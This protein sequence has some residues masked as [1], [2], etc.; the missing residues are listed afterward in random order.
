MDIGIIIAC[1]AMIGL[2]I[3]IVIALVRKAKASSCDKLDCCA[4]REVP[5]VRPIGPPPPMPSCPEKKV[6]NKRGWK[7]PSG[8]YFNDNDELFTDAGEMILDM[9]I[10]AQLCGEST[11]TAPNV[12]SL[13]PDPVSEP[14]PVAEVTSESS[15]SDLQTATTDYSASESTSCGGG[16]DSDGGDCGGGDD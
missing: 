2:A 1:G 5:G 8:H 15:F 16:S 11:T 4:D 10:I 9:M 13:A 14:A 6:R 3:V 7:A 12:E